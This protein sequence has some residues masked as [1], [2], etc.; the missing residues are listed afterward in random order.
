MALRTVFK[1]NDEILSKKCRKVEKYDQRLKVLLDDMKETMEKADGVGLAA[2][3]VG[4]LKRVAIIEVDDLYLEMVNPIIL[5]SEGE[6][7]DVEGCL[8]VDPSKN[9]KVKRP[10]K[11]V[12]QAYDKEGKLYKKEL[13]GMAARAVCHEID[14]LDGIL[15][16]K[17]RYKE[18]KEEK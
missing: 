18:D 1:E 15:F 7:I 9:C 14:H 12:L 11:L 4:L 10:N 13:E 17:R 3:Q 8:S 5:S 2:P 16:Y 6:Q